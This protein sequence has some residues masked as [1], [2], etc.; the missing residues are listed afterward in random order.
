MA[1]FLCRILFGVLVGTK[2]KLR[3]GIT[4]LLT[5]RPTGAKYRRSKF[6]LYD[7][8]MGAYNSKKWTG[9]C[10]AHCT[11]YNFCKISINQLPMQLG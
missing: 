9:D 11:A 3:Q 8:R 5:A 2:I 4:L 1:Y 6:I 7:R 10:L